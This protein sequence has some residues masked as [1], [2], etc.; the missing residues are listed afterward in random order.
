[1]M[2]GSG[3]ESD[4][5][6]AQENWE[7]ILIKSKSCGFSGNLQ[8]FEF[9]LSKTGK[10]FKYIKLIGR[11]NATNSWNYIS[12]FRI[13]G[14]DRYDIS[15]FSKQIAKIYPN[16]AR[17]FTNI[18]IVEPSF[19]PDFIRITTLSGRSVYEDKLDPGLN[20][21]QVPLKI[22]QGVYIVLLGK[23]KVPMF[24]QKLVVT[25]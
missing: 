4:L 8:V 18:M 24:T 21:F 3:Y 6:A 16:P 10:E 11:G 25:Y 13:F 12:E 9:P 15:D 22:K 20:Q 1:M 17:E 5:V 19:V 7:P 23:N 14:F 2:I